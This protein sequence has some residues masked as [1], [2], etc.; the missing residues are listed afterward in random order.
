MSQAM[1]QHT[2]E[3]LKET[4]QILDFGEAFALSED[5]SFLYV[6]NVIGGPFERDSKSFVSRIDLEGNMLEREWISGNMNAPKDICRYGGKLYLAD[7][8]EV[9]VID[10]ASAS[11]EKKIPAE[12]ANTLHNMTVNEK[13]V[14]YCSDMFSGTVYRLEDSVLVP[15]V[16]GLGYAAGIYAEGDDLYLLTSS[17]FGGGFFAGPNAS[18]GGER[19]Q[20][21]SGKLVKI[22]ADNTQTVLTESISAM[23]NG[24]TKIKE[25]E[26]VVTDWTGKMYYV[27]ADGTTEQLLD[28]TDAHIPCGMLHY[29]KA[30]SR[31]LMTTDENN[32][33]RIYRLNGVER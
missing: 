15:Y 31:L 4:D 28:Y 9:V 6:T 12:G 21:P 20:M 14:V 1:A 18:Q 32:T 16:T 25:G 29:D 7:L 5:G 10:I 24:I 27:N 23:G 2:V 19:P 11:I 26:F 30:T 22:A 17:G 33:V 8:S 3:L 13:G